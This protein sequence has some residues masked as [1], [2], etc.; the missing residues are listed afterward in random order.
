[1]SRGSFRTTSARRWT[2]GWRN[3]DGPGRP[4]RTAG[5]A[6][7]RGEIDAALL[8]GAREPGGGARADRRDEGG[9]AR[10]D[11]ACALD[12]PRPGGA[13]R[14]GPRGRRA[15]GGTGTRGA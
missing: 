10:G 1:M 14:E 2:T 7:P 9:P 12:R 11:Q 15:H 13:A 6:D 5:G 8:V 3:A 4:T